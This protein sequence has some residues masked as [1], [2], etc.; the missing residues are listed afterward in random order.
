[1]IRSPERGAWFRPFILPTESPKGVLPGI[2]KMFGY[3]RLFDSQLTYFKAFLFLNAHHNG[4]LPMQ[5]EVFWCLLLQ[6]D[7]EGPTYPHFMCSLVT[8]YLQS[9]TGFVPFKYSAS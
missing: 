7:S 9:I 4:S 1:M 6:A 2:G 3:A 5:L 8:H